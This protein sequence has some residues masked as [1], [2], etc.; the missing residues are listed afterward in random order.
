MIPACGNFMVS[1]SG[2]A[3]S[4]TINGQNF[5]TSGAG[6]IG[7]A[8]LFATVT[9]GVAPLTYEWTGFDDEGIQLL[10]NPANAANTTVQTTNRQSTGHIF[11][12]VW[13]SLG[14]FAIATG[15]DVAGSFGA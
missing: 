6:L 14:N 8:P 10:F 13:D 15:W 5:W 7:T 2:P 11:L 3:I 9:G 12:T 1:G 4:V